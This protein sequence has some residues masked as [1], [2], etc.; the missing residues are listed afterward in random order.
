MPNC[1]VCGESVASGVVLHSECYAKLIKENENLKFKL[2]DWKYNSLSQAEIIAKL[3]RENERL[4]TENTELKARFEKSIELPCEV[5]DKAQAL[6]EC[7]YLPH[8][9][10]ILHTEMIDCEIVVIKKNKKGIF[11]LVKPLIEEVW[12]AW[13]AY[14]WFPISTIN[15]TVFLIKEEAEQALKEC[16]KNE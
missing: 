14:K 1:K 15:K 13:L 16:E 7:F 5:G 6:K 12:G 4:T 9:T 10:R 11:I 3:V 2:E 8:A